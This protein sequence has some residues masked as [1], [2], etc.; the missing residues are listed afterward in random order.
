MESNAA[1]LD[2]SSLGDNNNKSNKK[3]NNNQN[4][5]TKYNNNGKQ[6]GIVGWIIPQ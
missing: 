3:N 2:K 5:K 1:L 6:R 4:N